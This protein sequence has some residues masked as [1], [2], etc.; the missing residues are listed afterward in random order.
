MKKRKSARRQAGFSLLEL[1]VAVALLTVI[2]GAIFSQI[3]TAQQNSSAEQVKMDLF[4]Q[5]REFMDQMGRDLRTAGYPNQRNFSTDPTSPVQNSQL[6]AAGLV[7]LDKGELWFEGSIDGSGTVSVIRYALNTADCSPLP[8]L[9]RS[10]SLKLPVAAPANILTGQTNSNPVTEVQNVLQGSAD[11]AL[12]ADPIFSAYLKD[13]TPVTLPVD[14]MNNAATIANI[15]TIAVKLTVQ[16]PYTDPKTHQVPTVTLFS[17]VRLTNCS[18][19]T[20]AS[21]STVMGC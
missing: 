17:T 9:R 21:G 13:G 7:K 18:A 20:S 10:Q 3:D 15:D 16:S 1:L 5:S 6:T 14:I 4:Q 12:D 11:H 8:C 2:M 19:A